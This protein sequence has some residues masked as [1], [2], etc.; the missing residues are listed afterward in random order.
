MPSADQA[1]IEYE[2]GQTLAA[3][4]VMTDA[5]AGTVHTLSGKTIWSGKSGYSPSIRPNGIVSGRN[6]LSPHADND[7]VTIAGFTAYSKGVLLTVTA[8]TASITRTA[9]TGKGQ[10]HS[11]TM[12][13]DGTIAVVEGT[14][15]SSTAFSETRNAAGGPPYI[16]ANDVEIGQVRVTA[17]TAAAIASSEIFQTVGTHAERFDYP[18]WSENNIGNG[19]SAATAGEKNAHIK[20]AAALPAIH[21]TAARKKVYAQVYTPTFSEVPRAVNFVPPDNTHSVNS[22]QIYQGT[23][24]SQS[25]TLG[26]GSFTSYGADG[27]TDGL[28]VEQDNVLTFRFYPDKDSAPYILCQGKLGVSRAYPPDNQIELSCTISSETKAA[29]FAS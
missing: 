3:Y 28:I 17:S 10:I 24:A 12:A 27:V 4:A 21:T 23:L 8:T 11:I 29:N 9:T 7:K 25:S 18:V 2:A 15:S 13:S 20:F 6:L 16:P 19:D 22:T 26:Q 5:G 1:K 14:I